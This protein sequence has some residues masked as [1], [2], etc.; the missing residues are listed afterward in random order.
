MPTPSNAAQKSIGATSLSPRHLWHRTEKVSGRSTPSVMDFSHSDARNLYLGVA[1]QDL[2]A[3]GDRLLL[4][5]E[6]H[7]PV[8]VP[9]G[10]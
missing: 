4:S 5:M 2:D 10:R 9:K 1:H 7:R 6:H 8:D 3:R